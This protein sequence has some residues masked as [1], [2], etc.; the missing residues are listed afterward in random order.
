M[1]STLSTNHGRV[2]IVC[3][4]A[5]SLYIFDRARRQSS[6]VRAAMRTCRIGVVYV[7]R[8]HRLPTVL[9]GRRACFL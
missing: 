4:P 6:L 2:A 8:R 5:V 9:A 1:S 7:H 3:V